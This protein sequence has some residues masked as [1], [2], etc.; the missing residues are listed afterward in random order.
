MPTPLERASL[1]GQL[2]EIAVKRGVL[3]SLLASTVTRPE[4]LDLGDW[5][6]RDAG[7]VYGS[8][9]RELRDVDMNARAHARETARHLFTL[10]MGLGQT[11][12]REYLR[13]IQGNGDL[14]DYRIHALWC[15]LQL[16]QVDRDRAVMT[17]EALRALGATFG[18]DGLPSSFLTEKG[19]TAWAD[20]LLW[21]AP[22]HPSLA[23]ELIC[24]EFSLNTPPE[25]LPYD[26]PAAH[27]TDL[28]RYARYTEQRGVFT[29]VC[30]EIAGETFALAP[31]IVEYFAAFTGKDKPLYKL[32]QAASYVDSTV[33]WIRRRGLGVGA[34]NTRAMSITQNGIESLAARY[35]PNQPDPRTHLLAGL[36]QA[37]REM[38][39][40][41]EGDDEAF[42][43]VIERAYNHICDSLPRP[44]RHQLERLRRAPL[45]GEDVAFDCHEDL[46]Q[47]CNPMQALPWDEAVRLLQADQPVTDLIGGDPQT[48]V[49][50]RLAAKVHAGSA[51]PLRDLHAAAIHAGLDALRPGELRVFG[52]EG[53]PGIGKT[54]AVVQ[55]LQDSKDG[56]LF[57]YVSPRVVINDTV[58]ADLTR[59]D[60][61][62]AAAR[63]LAVTTNARLNDAARASGE[64]ALRRDSAGSGPRVDSAVVVSGP[65]DLVLPRSSTL[66]LRQDER[67]ELERRHPGARFGKRSETERQDRVFD[68]MTPGVLSVLATPT[69]RLLE[70]NQQIDRVVLTAATQSY[71]TLE[72]SRTTVEALSH[73]FHDRANTAPAAPSASALRLAFPSSSSW[74]MKSRETAPARRLWMPWLAGWIKNCSTWGRTARPSA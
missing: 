61:G 27:L 23:H 2:F 33:A 49:A 72:A 28:L 73:L 12:M 43:D 52:L 34:F 59:R 29:R 65:K 10:G 21:L 46:E 32:C 7:D 30:A 6:S 48:V 47:L 74:W 13:S 18:L 54:T 35:D 57:V 1:W 36:G 8:M 58:T 22:A 60:A 26:E 56:F 68:K 53:N 62:A 51:L 44:L 4:R 63:T 11:T 66:V 31:D 17:E 55:W 42:D 19:R 71:R 24:M 40:L 3:I 50:A 25:P 16:P 20:F 41:P 14:E 45:P 64:E 69:R 38:K 9:E 67:E 37:Y 15:P 70:H 5:T 39:K